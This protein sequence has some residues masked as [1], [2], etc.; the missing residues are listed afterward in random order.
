MPPKR[1]TFWWWL[2]P[3][4]LRLPL[5]DLTLHMPP[6]PTCKP[7]PWPAG[8]AWGVG[9]GGLLVLRASSQSFLSQKQRDLGEGRSVPGKASCSGI[10][11]PAADARPSAFWGPDTA[12]QAGFDLTGMKELSWRQVTARGRRGRRGW[13]GLRLCVQPCRR[14]EWMCLPHVPTVGAV[15]GFLGVPRCPQTRCKL[16]T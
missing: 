1:T 4:R 11:A 13:A 6:A 2:F 3:A 5:G 16:V 12:G 14:V 8:Q 7:G 15:G 10:P 9:G